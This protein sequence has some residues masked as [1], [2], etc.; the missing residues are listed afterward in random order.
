[1]GAPFARTAPSHFWVSRVDFD[2]S[3]IGPVFLQLLPLMEGLQL[4]APRGRLSASAIVML[5]RSTPSRCPFEAQ[6]VIN[7][8][9]PMPKLAS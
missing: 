9:P 4:V 1:L 2:L 3:A 5:S 6:K 7:N 8:L